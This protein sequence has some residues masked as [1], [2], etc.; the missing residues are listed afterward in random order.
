M[1]N[2]TTIYVYLNGE[3]TDVWRPVKAVHLRENIYRIEPM[4]K[5]PEDETWQF[6]T[7]DVVRCEL[8]K[9]SKGIENKSELVAFEK[10]NGASN[11]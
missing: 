8:K 2:E 1:D 3:G 4:N 7:G 9:L 10:I 5:N 6:A 11:T